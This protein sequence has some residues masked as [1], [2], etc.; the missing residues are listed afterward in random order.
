MGA[1]FGGVGFQMPV[2]AKRL[3][4]RPQQGE[5]HDGKGVEQ[6]QPV[7][8][9]RRIYPHGSHPHAETQILRIAQS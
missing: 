2:V 6:P 5:Q 9:F 4:C 7:S 8:T 3:A 1:V